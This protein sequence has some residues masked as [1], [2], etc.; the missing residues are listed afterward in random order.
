VGR[1][2]TGERRKRYCV[3]LSR[4]EYSHIRSL[5]KEGGLTMSSYI[6]AR[7]VYGNTHY[8][9]KRKVREGVKF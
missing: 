5:A 7:I 2:S 6:R 1:L 8:E 3:C 9:A 4:E